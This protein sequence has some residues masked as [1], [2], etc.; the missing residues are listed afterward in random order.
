MKKKH[1]IEFIGA[2]IGAVVGLVLVNSE[3]LWRSL[4]HGVVLESWVYIL[5]AANLSM[6][7]QIVGNFVLAIYRPAHLYSFIQALMTVAG[8]VSVIVFF[9][10]FPVDFSQIVGSW[11]NL[12]LKVALGLAMFGSSIGIIVYLVRTVIG[13]QYT[14]AAAN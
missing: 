4:T 3:P 14:P 6:I 12:L 9:N 1:T 11:M 7:A 8:L 2:I 13:T 5:W 10:V